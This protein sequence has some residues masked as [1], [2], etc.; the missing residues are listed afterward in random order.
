VRALA[1]DSGRF[2]APDAVPAQ[3]IPDTM[4]RVMLSDLLV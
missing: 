4:V 3:V 1:S 2:A